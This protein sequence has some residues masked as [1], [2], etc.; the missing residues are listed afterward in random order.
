MVNSLFSYLLEQSPEKPY[1]LLVVSHDG[2]DDVNETG[3][4]LSKTASGMGI[5]SFIAETMGAYT[6]DI[7]DGKLF[8]SFKVDDKGVAHL[9]SSKEDLKYE[10][11]FKI[12]PDKTLIMMRGLHPMYGCESWRVMAKNLE[13]EGYKLINSVK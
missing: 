12:S 8:Y 11:P 10:E 4:L 6:E 1:D 2:I 5:K 3:P 9:P 13:H 7:S